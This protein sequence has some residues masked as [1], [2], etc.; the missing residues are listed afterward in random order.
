MSETQDQGQTTDQSSAP[1]FR[2]Q[3]MQELAAERG[4]ESEDQPLSASEEDVGPSSASDEADQVDAIESVEESEDQPEADETPAV[5]TVDGT[6]Y[7]PEDIRKMSDNLGK[8]DTEFRRRT[9]ITA[10]LKQEYDAAGEELGQMQGLFAGLA[11]ANVQQYQRVD[12]S[13]LTPEQYKVYHQQMAS[14]VNGRNK[15]QETIDKQ[16][17]VLKEKRT[18]LLDRQAE[19]SIDVLKGI[20]KRWGDEFYGQVREFAVSTGRYSP[21]EFQDL[22]D[23]RHIEGLVALMDRETLPQKVGDKKIQ[24]PSKERRRQKQTRGNKGQFQSLQQ[25]VRESTNARADGSFQALKRAQLEREKR[26]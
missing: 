17:K 16:N 14:A 3:K 11:D 10:R 9:Q 2:D 22:T 25:R 21:E 6:E 15:L 4:G 8:Y 19:E 24:K 20:E 18:Q 1:S 7:S 23:W 12:P 13:T 5:F 26:G